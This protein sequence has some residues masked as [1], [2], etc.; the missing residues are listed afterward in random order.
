MALSL[1]SLL[2]GCSS[3]KPYPSKRSGLFDRLGK[4]EEASKYSVR[5]KDAIA[6]IDDDEDFN[7][8]REVD[9]IDEEQLKL[10]KAQVAKW[11]W[12][13]TDV[14]VTSR[15]GQR[16][17]EFHE[18]VDLRAKIGTP[19]Y[20]VDGGK[21]IYSG[22]KI[23][24]YG[25]MVVI[26]H[27]SGLSTVYAHNSKLLVKQGKKIKAGQKIAISGNTGRVRGAH[28]HFE[29]RQGVVALDPSELLPS[30]NAVATV[31]PKPKIAKPARRV[32]SGKP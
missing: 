15:F 14:Q 8:G 26:R 11:R 22:S 17:N 18:G 32:A 27:D 23:R 25:K 29:V 5:R 9:E 6:A 1:A 21:V 19:V 3:A 31:E 2:G 30:R 4:L 24:G 10:L 20:A 13:L 28:V 7:R 12:P 16:G